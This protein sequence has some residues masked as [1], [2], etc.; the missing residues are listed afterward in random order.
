MSFVP[1]LGN[2]WNEG[3]AMKMNRSLGGIL[4]LLLLAG[5]VY[6]AFAQAQQVPQPRVQVETDLGEDER[7]AVAFCGVCA[8]LGLLIPILLLGASIG[9]AIWVYRDAQRRGN[10]QALVWSI[11][12]FFLN[13]V[14]LI[15]YLV[16]RPPVQPPPP[17]L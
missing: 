15:I 14:G 8:G 13:V 6:P 1:A 2:R 9:I 16:A 17:A 7:A 12:G 4:F 10:P 11:L 3:G 5:C